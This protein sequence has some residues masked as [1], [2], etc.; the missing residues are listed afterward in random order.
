MTSE[1]KAPERIYFNS[2]LITEHM[3][4]ST[5]PF[6]GGTEYIRAD[7]AQAMVAGAYEAAVIPATDWELGPEEI[8]PAIRALTPADASAALAERER[9][10]V[11]AAEKG[12]AG[13]A[14]ALEIILSRLKFD[15]QTASILK[16]QL[17]S[18]RKSAAALKKEAS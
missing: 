16:Y 15:D 12:P 2:A 5:V 1:P 6:V 11:K 3:H 13:T 14:R 10:A 8:A 7:A 18:E 4:T 17:G 9:L